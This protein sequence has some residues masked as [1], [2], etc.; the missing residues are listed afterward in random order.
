MSTASS[1]LASPPAVT[2]ITYH[3]H[4]LLAEDAPGWPITAA[5]TCTSGHER[6]PLGGA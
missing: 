6:G 4:P 5:E 1:V 3:R 2:T